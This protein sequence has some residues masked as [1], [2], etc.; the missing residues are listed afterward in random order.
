[1]YIY[2]YIYIPSS[3]F[4]AARMD[5]P[6]SL[7]PFCQ[8][9]ITSVGSSRQHL[10]SV[11]SCCRKVL[12]ARPTLARPCKGVPSENVANGFVFALLAVSR[13]FCLSSLDGLQGGW[14]VA[15]QLLFRRMLLPGFVWYNSYYAWAIAF[16]PFIYALSQRISGT[17][18]Q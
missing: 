5:F 16:K 7:S 8:P 3:S 2:I 10:V 1:M 6:K 13:M 11:Q 14:L 15:I 17:S 12:A 9:S 4:R 18:I